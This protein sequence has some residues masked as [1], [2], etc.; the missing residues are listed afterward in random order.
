MGHPPR[1]MYLQWGARSSWVPPP[2]LIEIN[3]LTPEYLP[4]KRAES[5]YRITEKNL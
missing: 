3:P 2:F 5:K 1:C 4:L